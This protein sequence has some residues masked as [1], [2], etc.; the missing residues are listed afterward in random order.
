MKGNGKFHSANSLA[1]S[2][3]SKILA[4][5]S[6]DG[7]IRL[8]SVEHG[9]D[10][11]C[12]IELLGHHNRGCVNVAFSLDEQTLASSSGREDGT[13]CLWNSYEEDRN[14]QFTQVDWDMV[15]TAQDI[16][17]REAIMLTDDRSE[18]AFGWSGLPR[19][20]WRLFKRPLL[21]T[22]L[23]YSGSKLY[24][25]GTSDA[26]ALNPA[27]ITVEDNLASYQA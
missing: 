11:S 27:V 6:A 12:L 4:S 26:D 13:V 17:C 1:F 24:A 23:G 3:N 21:P 15:E 2:P 25:Q 20:D 7:S 18:Y 8:K 9:G 16:A 14:H 10:D 5:A 19:K 22:L